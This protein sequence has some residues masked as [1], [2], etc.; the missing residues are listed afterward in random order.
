M[1]FKFFLSFLVLLFLLNNWTSI[2]QDD[3][4]DDLSFESNT[5]NEESKPYFGV[6]GGYTGTFLFVNFDELNKHIKDMGFSDEFKAPIYLNGG[7]GFIVTFF[8]P[9][10]RVAILGKGGSALIEKSGAG[11]PSIEYSVGFTGIA[12][13]YALVPIK[14][15]SL[16]FIPGVAVGRGRLTIEAF[17][18]EKYDWKKFSLT[19]DSL[20]VLNRIETGFWF[21]EPKLNIEWAITDFFM[22]R[23]GAGYSLWAGQEWYY[24]R[25]AKL[26]NVPPGI[27]ANGLTLQVG[28]F[29]GLFNY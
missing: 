8:V 4:L 24:N 28:A 16:A 15:L 27:N 13:D 29:V 9:N 6:A 1:K 12:L 21:F 10:L 2:A 25:N 3:Q 22:L 26:E 14:S 23:L 19:N 17:Q 5:L 7:E 20:N 11:N 18:G